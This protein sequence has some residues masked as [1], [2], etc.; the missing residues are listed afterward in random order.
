MPTGFEVDKVA[1][2][3]IKEKGFDDNFLHGLGHPLGFTNPHGAGVRLS[4]KKVRAN[5]CSPLQKMVGYTIEPGIYLKNK[6]GLRS[7]IDFYIDEKNKVVITTKIQK[8]I[9]KI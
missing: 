9:F 5:R 8:K 2:D 1:R 7:E 6:F 4:P 3:Y